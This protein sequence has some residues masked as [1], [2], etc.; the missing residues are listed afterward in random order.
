[1]DGITIRRVRAD[2]RER[3]AEHFRQ[4]SPSSRYFRFFSPRRA[5]SERELDR[6]ADSDGSRQ[7]A[8][9]AMVNEAGTERIVGLAQYVATGGRRADLA[10]SVADR[11]QGRGLGR[12]LMGTLI[13][14]AR[15]NGI[16]EF[17]S[18]VLGDNQRMLQ[19]LKRNGLA[20]HRSTEAGVVHV[21]FS[22]AEADALRPAA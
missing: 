21:T 6:F 5:V 13:A 17:E 10:C 9:A 7:A 3:I 2:D 22:G 4:L 15:A 18:D 19:F 8:V 12:L 11:Y 20:K 14:L 1:M 16:A